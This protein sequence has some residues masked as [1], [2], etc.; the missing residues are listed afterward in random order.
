MEELL[1]LMHDDLKFAVWPKEDLSINDFWLRL[2]CIFVNLLADAFLVK[3][4]V[5]ALSLS[6]DDV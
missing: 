1:D 4:C 6:V 2:V 3:L 5:R